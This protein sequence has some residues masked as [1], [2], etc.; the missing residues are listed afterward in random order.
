[1]SAITTLLEKTLE[2]HRSSFCQLISEIV[3]KGLVYRTNK[4][5]P[6]T[7][8]EIQ[9]LNEL[10]TR[11]HFKIPELW[12]PLFLDTLPTVFHDEGEKHDERRP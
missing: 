4:R 1:M 12:D 5:E 7:R 9:A 3:R 2:T 10:I 8:E 6:I 11:V